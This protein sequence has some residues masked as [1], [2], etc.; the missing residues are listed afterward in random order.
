[1]ASNIVGIVEGVLPGGICKV[2][3]GEGE[4]MFVKNVFVGQLVKWK[5]IE[6]IDVTEKEGEE[7]SH[8]FS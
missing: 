2:S 6:S 8:I 3:H 4:E 1:M 7:I 5:Q